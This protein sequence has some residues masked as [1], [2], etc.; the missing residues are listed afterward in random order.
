MNTP[1]RNSELSPDRSIEIHESK[2]L[3]GMSLPGLLHEMSLLKKKMLETG[4]RTEREIEPTTERETRLHDVYSTLHERGVHISRSG[5]LQP[6]KIE[7]SSV[8]IQ[9]ERFLSGSDDPDEEL[10]EAA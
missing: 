6:E 10:D 4:E 1:H 3:A 7:V 2:D 8:R 5:D 9:V